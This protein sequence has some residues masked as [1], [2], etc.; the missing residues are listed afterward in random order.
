MYLHYIKL[1]YMREKQQR[2][3]KMKTPKTRQDFIK[4]KRKLEADEEN[5]KLFYYM[6]VDHF[7]KIVGKY[8]TGDLKKQL[9]KG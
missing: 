2:M 3:L 1:R 8:F 5:G 9:M 4:L 7:I 6:T